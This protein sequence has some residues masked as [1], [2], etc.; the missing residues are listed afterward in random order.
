MARKQ[1]TEDKRLEQLSLLNKRRKGDKKR[2][3]NYYMGERIRGTA[4]K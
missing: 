4:R 1:E 3:Q 2:G